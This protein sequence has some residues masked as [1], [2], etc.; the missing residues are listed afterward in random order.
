MNRCR[1][2][3]PYLVEIQFINKFNNANSINSRVYIF[4]KNIPNENSGV[5][6]QAHTTLDIPYTYSASF[7][8]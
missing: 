3:G 4:A 5:L 7:L 2:N 8:I 1:T 6:L